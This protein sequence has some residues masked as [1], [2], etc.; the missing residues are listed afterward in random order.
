M[1]RTAFLTAALALSST[2]ANAQ[3]TTYVGPPRVVA[4]TPEAIALADS[5]T[6]DSVERTAMTNMKDWVDSASGV[7]VP[8]TVGRVDSAALVNDPGR[9]ITTFSDGSVAPATAS[10]LPL[11]M[12]AGL[13]A[14]G[15]GLLIL[16]RRSRA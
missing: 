1:L 2:L 12:V 11:L 8:A 13:V 9:P 10:D 15:L 6:R 16:K 4:P 14:L 3:V 7:A 5:A